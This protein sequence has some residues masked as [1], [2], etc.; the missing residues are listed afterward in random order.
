MAAARLDD[1]DDFEEEEEE[2]GGQRRFD[3]GD[4]APGDDV[5]PAKVMEMFIRAC[6]EMGLDPEEMLDK[7]G[8][9]PGPF[10]IPGG[11]PSKGK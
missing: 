9:L 11:K 10:R 8:G 2:E 4:D 7:I 6:R 5:S 1:V 3:W